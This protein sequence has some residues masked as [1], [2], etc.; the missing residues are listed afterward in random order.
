M[1]AIGELLEGMPRA[2]RRGRLSGMAERQP[3]EVVMCEPTLRVP[4]EILRTV[5]RHIEEMARILA[6]LEPESPFWSSVRKS[7][8]GLEV[9]AWKFKFRME[10]DKLVLTTAEP[11]PA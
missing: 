4:P 3:I 1:A 11:V 6:Q 8:L 10:A 9:L 5:Q 7:G 2:S